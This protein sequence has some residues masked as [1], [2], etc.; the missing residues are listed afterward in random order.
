MKRSRQERR[1][2]NEG[3]SAGYFEGYSQGYL[4]GYL[5]GYS[6]GLH[7][8]NPVIAIAEA[9]KKVANNPQI[10]QALKEAEEQYLNTLEIV[11]GGDND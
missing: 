5:Q 3:K 11:E 10:Q 1:A 9:L 4:Q 6:K 7:D 8:G 2:Y